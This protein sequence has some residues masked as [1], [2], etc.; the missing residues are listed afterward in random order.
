MTTIKREVKISIRFKVPFQHLPPEVMYNMF[1][2]QHSS[3]KLQ[4]FKVKKSFSAFR[5]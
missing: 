5:D 2:M 3:K 1:T 4:T